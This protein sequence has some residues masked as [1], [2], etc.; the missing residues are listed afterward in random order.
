MAARSRVKRRCASQLLVSHNVDCG[1]PRKEESVKRCGRGVPNP[2]SSSRAPHRSG[3]HHFPCVAGPVLR[4]SDS[5]APGRIF[6]L[7]HELLQNFKE[8]LL[9]Y[10]RRRRAARLRLDRGRQVPERLRPPCRGA[11]VSSRRHSRPSHCGFSLEDRIAPAFR[12]SREKQRD[13]SFCPL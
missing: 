11:W 10:E 13:L 12:D 7:Q 8:L 9:P 4:G 1:Q 5:S 2:N 6:H 3:W